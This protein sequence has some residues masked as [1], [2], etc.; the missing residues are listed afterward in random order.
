MFSACSIHD[1]ASVCRPSLGP[2]EH[3]ECI[4]CIQELRENGK[5]YEAMNQM[6]LK[7]VGS[8]KSLTSAK[9]SCL[10]SG[11]VHLL[12]C[13]IVHHAIVGRMLQARWTTVEQNIHLCKVVHPVMGAAIH[14]SSLVFLQCIA[15]CH[16]HL[17]FPVSCTYRPLYHDMQLWSRTMDGYGSWW[18]FAGCMAAHFMDTMFIWQYLGCEVPCFRFTL[19]L[20]G[21]A[22]V[23]S[24]RTILGKRLDIRLGEGPRKFPM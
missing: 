18:L 16:N 10:Q 6:I 20:P 17:C 12:I 13:C 3:L 7:N 1:F 4:T 21:T 14:F 5:Q 8:K 23:G 22:L 24:T 9:G 2:R 15:P 19:L 11:T